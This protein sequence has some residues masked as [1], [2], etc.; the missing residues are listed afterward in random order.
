MFSCVYS[1]GSSMDCVTFILLG[2]TKVSAGFT[3]QSR[4][5]SLW[6]SSENPSPNVQTETMWKLVS[7]PSSAP[8]SEKAEVL[9][10][11]FKRF[12]LHGAASLFSVQKGKRLKELKKSCC[13]HLAMITCCNLWVL[14]ADNCDL[15]Q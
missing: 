12:N 9:P 13:V 2:P 7:W 10:H 1:G 8:V 4:V 5:T 3:I 15:T 11:G 6:S 14:S